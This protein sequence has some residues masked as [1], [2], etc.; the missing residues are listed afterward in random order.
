[1]ISILIPLY[2]GIEFLE[3]SVNSVINQTYSQ[4]ELLIGVNGYSTNSD[5]YF[6]AKEY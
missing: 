1:M 3:E 4:W 6:K 2:N 5:I